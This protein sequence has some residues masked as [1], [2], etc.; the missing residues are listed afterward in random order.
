MMKKRQLLMLVPAALIAVASL[1]VPHTTGAATEIVFWHAMAG[2]NGKVVTSLVADFNASHADIHITEQ[3]KGNYNDTLNAVIQAA[4]QGQ[5]PDIAQIFDLGTPLMADSGFFTPIQDLMTAEQLTA[6]KADVLPPVLN[7]FT[8]N[9][10]LNSMPWNN[11]NPLL[12]YNKD[13]FTAAGLD[14]TKP[15][16]TWQELEADCAK[17]IA[18]NAAP[19]CFSMQLY[20]WPFEQWMALQGAEL[21]NNGNGRSARATST[22]LTSDAAKNIV[23]FWKDL[24]DK[25]YWVYT[26]KLEDGAGSDQIFSTKQAAIL[27]ESTGTLGTLV[28]AAATNN[29][30]LGT[31]FMPA[32]ANV[33]RAGVIIGGAS[34]WVANHPTAQQQAAV[35]FILWLEQPAQMAKW[36]Q[37]TGYL[38]ITKSAQALLTSQGWYDKNPLAKTAVDQLNATTPNSATSGAIMGAYPQIRTLVEQVIQ[39]VVNGNA[40]VDDALATAKTKADQALTDYNSRLA[41]GTS[42]TM[43]ATMSS[44]MSGT[45]AASATMAATTAATMAPAATMS[46]TMAATAA[47]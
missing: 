32:N 22:N 15:P 20:G 27:I 37:G 1:N 6:I 47:H 24:N 4:G 25:K 35:T 17:I 13:M 29:F 44:T 12:Y 34:L 41:A 33:P 39:S 19:N 31:G 42:A 21:T 16:A 26:G 5:G 30:Q 11:S 2:T 14:A 18:S 9:G 45:T 43:A 46:A 3:N 8:I 23:N 40:T 36:H 28:K 7:Y 10:K 38:P